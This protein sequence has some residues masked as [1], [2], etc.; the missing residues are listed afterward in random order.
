VQNSNPPPCENEFCKFKYPSN[1]FNILTFYEYINMFIMF[2]WIFATGKWEQ[3]NN[4]KWKLK[5]I[6]V[7]N[8]LF[9]CLFVCLFS[10]LLT[11]LLSCRYLLII[12]CLQLYTC[13]YILTCLH[14]LTCCI[15]A[16]N[17]NNVWYSYKHTSMVA[18]I[19]RQLSYHVK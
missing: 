15:Y 6:I 19:E 4:K 17:F 12:V 9:V 8:Y 3:Q 11:C 13:S 18:N 2:K 1:I 7:L 14:Y 10:Y 5:R 16:D